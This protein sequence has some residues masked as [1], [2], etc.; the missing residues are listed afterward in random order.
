MQIKPDW[1]NGGF[2]LGG[3]ML[4]WLNVQTLYRAKK[5]EGVHWGA[6]AFFTFW[7]IW[8]LYYFPS[9]GQWCSFVGGCSIAA[10]NATW[11]ALA[12]YYEKR[13]REIKA[14]Q[15]RGGTMGRTE[16]GSSCERH[17]TSA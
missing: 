17:R 5:V 4:L 8:N 9:L 12:I 2:E 3:S 16:V 7:G 1:I 10:A 6:S 15:Q 14:N 11:V 13:N